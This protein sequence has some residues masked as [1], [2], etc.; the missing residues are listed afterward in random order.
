MR[1]NKSRHLLIRT[2]NLLSKLRM[3]RIV[4]RLIGVDRINQNVTYEGTFNNFSEVLSTYKE[5]VGY[6]SKEYLI[7]EG[8]K[9]S[10]I[11]ANPPEVYKGNNRDNYLLHLLSSIPHDKIR[12]LDVGSG[13]GLT[14][15]FLNSN[16]QKEIEY[17]GV[18]LEEISDIA[19]QNFAHHRNFHQVNLSNLRNR[20]FDVVYFGSSLQYF[21]DY[22]KTLLLTLASSPQIVLIADTPVGNLETFVTCQV[23]M[24]NRKIPRWVFSISEIKEIFKDKEYELIEIASVDWHSDIHNF[25]NFS[26]EYHHISHKNLVFSRNKNL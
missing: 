6:V 14:F 4:R 8:N 5:N 18:D 19:L 1:S 16:L 26:E 24:K 17:T 22:R 25:L 20:N 2:K 11:L 21:E 15:L 13:F 12:I 10:E 9:V 3:L 23:N 7:S